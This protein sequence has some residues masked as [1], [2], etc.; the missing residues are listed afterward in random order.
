MR[1]AADDRLEVA[2]HHRIGVRA[3]RRADDVEGGRDVRHPVAQRLVHRVLERARARRHRHDLGAEQAHAEDVGLL[4]LD[5]RLAHE[6]D[7]RQAE[8]RADGGGRDAVLARAG[9]GDD[10]RLAH[11]ARQQHLADAVV[12]LVRAGV[13]ELVALEVDFRAADNAWSA[14]R[15]NTSAMGG[16]HSAPAASRTPAWNAG[17]ALARAIF[18]LELEHER[19]QR[20]G[21]IASAKFAKTAVGV[22]PLGPGV[23][24]VHVY[25]GRGRRAP[26]RLSPAN[27]GG[28]LA[29]ARQSGDR[30]PQPTAFA[31]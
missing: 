4:P 12:D 30:A 11:A 14:A 21:D 29:T 27:T 20:F 10:A 31:A 8:A 22:G 7:A 28:G 1:F 2:H 16:R 3:R 18:L 19:H 17:S 24:A 13:V 23:V 15:R 26:A 9:F 6:H 5:I 25:H